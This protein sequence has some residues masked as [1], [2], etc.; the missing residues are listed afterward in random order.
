[1]KN[2]YSRWNPYRMKI[3]WKLEEMNLIPNRVYKMKDPIKFSKDNKI[4]KLSEFRLVKSL[5]IS[6]GYF[7]IYSNDLLIRVYSQ[8]DE[9]GFLG[10][11]R[12][13]V[14]KIDFDTIM[15]LIKTRR[16]EIS[17]DYYLKQIRKCEK[18]I[19]SYQKILDPSLNRE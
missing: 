1:M 3:D 15:H 8:L 6:E 7:R 2:V 12:K 14:Y 4:F 16:F 10:N 18:S 9:V 11:Y 19:L 17:K 13:P 5:D